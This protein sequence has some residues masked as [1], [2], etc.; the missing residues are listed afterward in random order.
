MQ[1]DRVLL[2]LALYVDVPELP[3]DPAAAEGCRPPRWRG[4]S[5]V[6]AASGSSTPPSTF[7]PARCPQCRCR[8]TD[9]PRAAS[10]VSA[11]P[12]RPE[13]RRCPPRWRPSSTSARRRPSSVTARAARDP[14]RP[15]PTATSHCSIGCGRIMPGATRPRLDALAQRIDPGPAWD[16]LVLPAGGADGAAAPDRRPGRPAQ[17]RLRHLGL[18]R[19]DEPRPRH[20]RPVRRCRAAPARRW[21]PR[22]SPASCGSTSTGSTCRPVVSK[23]IGETEKN[24]RRVFDAAEAGGASCSS[25]RPTRCSAS[26]PRSTTATTATPTSRSTTCCS[27]WRPTAASP[28]SPRTCERARRRV[29]AP[30]AL[31]RRVPVPRRRRPSPHLG[32]RLPDRRGS[33]DGIDHGL[34][35]RLELSGGNIRSIALNAAFLAAAGSSSPSTCYVLRAAAREYTK[36]AK[37]IS[38]AEF[39]GWVTVARA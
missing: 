32:A 38:A 20:H 13:C 36:L 4:C 7:G 22:C 28:S 10:A 9:R 11:C 27:G 17:H 25:T 14:A 23:Y 15:R 6:P 19:A 29:P 1:R 18:R 21:R 31:R 24:L 39:G 5:G 33:V 26:A 16:D 12:R 8:H 35:S 3:A 34:L 2:P 37:P 30:A